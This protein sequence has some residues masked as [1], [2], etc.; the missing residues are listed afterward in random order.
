MKKSSFI[1]YV[2]LVSFSLFLDLAGKTQEAI[3][4]ENILVF[5]LLLELRGRK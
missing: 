1:W 3:I 5:C 4:V 2:A